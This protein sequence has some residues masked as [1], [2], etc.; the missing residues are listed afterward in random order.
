MQIRSPSTTERRPLAA[1]A[2]L[3]F[4]L[5]LIA[6]SAAQIA[7]RAAL[8]TEGWTYNSGDEFDSNSVVFDQNVL[9]GPSPIE[10][11][12]ELIEIAGVA[13]APGL[14]GS[15]LSDGWQVGRTVPYVV[16]RGSARLTLAVPLKA[17]TAGALLRYNFGTVPALLNGLMPLLM[18]LI[19]LF[20][21]WQRPAEPAGWA[22]LL[23][24]AVLFA[25]A[26]SALVPD[27]PT[28]QVSAVW[29]VAAFYSYWI[30]GILIGPSLF[31]LS[32]TFPRPKRLLARFPWLGVLPFTIFWL[33][34]A[35]FG[36]R[37]EVGFGLTGV[38]FLLT[39][40]SLVHS[41]FTQR[42][43]VSRAQFMWGLAGLLLAVLCFAPVFAGV[44]AILLG[45][46]DDQLGIL[47]DSTLQNVNVL[48]FPAFTVCLAVA[49][50]RYRLWDI[51]VILRRTLVYGVLTGLLALAYFGAVVMLE[52]LVRPLTGHS[53]NA[54][55]NVIS[56]L[57]IAALFGPLRRRVQN[58]IDRR[59]YRRKYDA[60]QVIA[61]FGSALRD[62]VALEQ[63]TAQLA[64]TAAAAV[65]PSQVSV[66]LP[67]ASPKGRG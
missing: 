10:P 33:L 32:L 9:G 50:L 36:L 3:L 34:T 14:L 26:L 42:D 67:P 28:T 22:L 24:A 57:L 52:Q 38:F 48:A 61:A 53:Q 11:G 1:W 31:L 2:V 44:F 54:L 13:V 6:G 47:K 17:W 16:Q 19:A 45:V 60:A 12:D 5:A 58:F 18:L 64:D 43:A 59:F 29:W 35:V 62:E 49:I 46:P 66:W 20:V 8:P 4:A 63:V 15:N 7:Y 55:V 21:F 56:T 25:N 23:L 51:E 40:L 41:L 39:L 37:A 65:Q 30:F 27:G